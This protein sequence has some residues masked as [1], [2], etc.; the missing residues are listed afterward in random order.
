MIGIPLAGGPCGARGR[1][2]GSCL[3]L[4]GPYFESS[5]V[6]ILPPQRP[7]CVVILLN[8]AICCPSSAIPTASRLPLAQTWTKLRQCQY[9]IPRYKDK[10]VVCGCLCCLWGLQHVPVTPCPGKLLGGKCQQGHRLFQS[11]V[12]S[13]PPDPVHGH[14]Q[15]CLFDPEAKVQFWS[16]EPT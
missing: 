10:A 13:M 1:S 9:K 11:P 12:S 3:Q 4:S 16:R 7:H 15:M 5:Q 8:G 14:R 2:W 6:G